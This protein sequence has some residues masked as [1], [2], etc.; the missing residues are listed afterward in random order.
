M[1]MPKPSWVLC[2][3]VLAVGTR[4]MCS[5]VS[6]GTLAPVD[7]LMPRNPECNTLYGD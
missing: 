6:K 5:S 7:V 1:K 3:N 4:S 2:A